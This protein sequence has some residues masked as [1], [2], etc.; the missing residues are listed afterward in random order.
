MRWRADGG[1][2]RPLTT[3]PAGNAESHR[4]PVFLP[5]GKH[6]LYQVAWKA[7]RERQ[8]NG[9][10][11]GSL[12][13]QEIKLLSPDISSKFS[14]V[15]GFLLFF[16]QGS[17]VAQRFDPDRLRL[18]GEL[19]PVVRQELEQDTGFSTAAF[20]ASQ[21]GTLV[22][23]SVAT[24]A[25]K[26]TWFD[27]KGNELGTVGE[28][29]YRSP[30]LSP[31]GR[32]VAVSFDKDLNGN[33]GIWVYDLAR[34]MSTAVVAEGQSDY[35]LWSPDGK[36]VLYSCYRDGTWDLC[37]KGVDDG[38]QEQIVLRGGLLIPND[39]SADGHVVYMNF[40]A[41]VPQLWTYAVNGSVHARF[42]ADRVE[43]R[44]SP[45]GNWIVGHRPHPDD[46]AIESF[47]RYGSRIQVSNSP[48]T[49]PQWR[50]DGQELFYLAPD[51]KL[52]AVSVSLR[53]PAPLI[54]IPHALF[55]TRINAADF[56]LFQYAVS[57][58]GQ[59]FLINSLPEENA[60][61]TLLVNWT[62]GTIQ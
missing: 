45:D 19:I 20:S 60:P 6:F 16:H 53:G 49:Q 2:P 50:G 44:I 12:D 54:G 47:P 46:I 13:S 52:M 14:L 7:G 62:A 56:D 31:D 4:W 33:R 35:P 38:S 58:D 11:V 3:S 59:R 32:R 28:P 26:L 61:L 57:A 15:S 37:T 51:R 23:Q 43:S 10:Y 29:R 5:D 41:R 17:L 22:Y 48:G 24:S 1:E 30:R 18:S 9:I 27:R 25:S 21:N 40:L 42:V 36:S 34:Q 39:W 55:Q 8:G